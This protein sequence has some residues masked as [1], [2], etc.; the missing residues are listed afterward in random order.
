ME[1]AFRQQFQ[2]LAA[3]VARYDF[4]RTMVLIVNPKSEQPQFHPDAQQALA[5]AVAYLH[6][7]CGQ[8]LAS[9]ELT[10]N[11]AA[12]AVLAQMAQHKWPK[13]YHL[14]LGNSRLDSA[15]LRQLAQCNWGDWFGVNLSNCGLDCTGMAELASRSWHHLAK[16]DLSGNHLDRAAVSALIQADWPSL[17]NLN[18]DDNPGLD[19]ADV[20]M[21][22]GGVRSQRLCSLSLKRIP[23]NVACLQKIAQ[24]CQ[25]TD[26]RLHHNSLGKG[27]VA[28][29]LSASWPI[30]KALTLSSN[31]LGA[32]TL[33][34]LVKVLPLSSN[35]L[36]ADKFGHLVFDFLQ[37]LSTLNLAGNRLD[38]AAMH[39]LAKGDWCRLE[40]L[41]LSDND[42]G[43]TAMAPLAE[44][45]WPSLATLHLEG[46][47]LTALGLKALTAGKWPGLHRLML[48]SRAV[49]VATWTTLSLAFEELPHCTS[50]PVW[51]EAQRDLAALAVAS[52]DVWPNLV[53]VEFTSF[54]IPPVYVS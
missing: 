19:A 22:F 6:T 12:D 53:A 23:L 41:I 42:L 29:L 51:I 39:E 24:M 49:S 31:G 47:N 33:R 30:M 5:A 46:N 13:I 38:T 37:G 18:L 11:M 40:C 50:V 17:R 3:L 48:D 35:G 2:L 16:L 54:D 26:L 44:G 28:C 45:Q 43:D 8:H 34:H 10:I 4:Q 32:H 27:A 20:A 15:A 7:S 14:D 52:S 25:L 21:L 9:F 1:T 36:E